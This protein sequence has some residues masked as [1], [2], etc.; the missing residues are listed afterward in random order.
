MV[1]AS[2]KI[3]SKNIEG[4]LEL[5][6]STQS[7]VVRGPVRNWVSFSTGARYSN[8]ERYTRGLQVTGEFVPTFWD[9]QTQARFK[10]SAYDRIDVFAATF[11]SD[12]KMKPKK[13]RLRYNCSVLRHLRVCDEFAGSGSGTERF[14]YEGD[15]VA[16]SWTHLA[17][18][19][20]I[21]AHVNFSRSNERE[22]TDVEYSIK[23]DSIRS[24]ER[25]DSGLRLAKIEGGLAGTRDFEIVDLKVGAGAKHS[26]LSGKM[27]SMQKVSYD[28]GT[29][30]DES[31][32]F[33]IDRGDVD[34]FLYFQSKWETGSASMLSGI[35][36]VRF[37]TT[38][39]RLFLPRLNIRLKANAGLAFTLSAGRHAQPPFY[40]EYVVDSVARPRLK[41][42]KSDQFGVGV[43]YEL[44]NSLNW[45][46]EVF[47]RDQSELISYQIDDL[48]IVYSGKN[49]SDGFAYGINTKT[50]GQLDSLIGI[51]SY[52]YL[53]AREDIKGD[54]RRNIPRPVD[55]RH[56]VSVY[57]EDRMYL[58]FLRL[59]NLLYS[60]FHIRMLYGSG[61]P[62]TPQ[63][64]AK[65]QIGDPVLV[66]GKR[67]SRRD[68][69]YLR[70]DIGMTQ[71]I[72]IAGKTMHLHQE[73]ANMFDQHN[74]VGYSYFPSFRGE[75]VEVR[76]S[77][78][79]RVYNFSVSVKF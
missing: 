62:H 45:T 77:L 67:N 66:E 58:E 54:S 33:T 6:G 14:K 37:G 63:V 53:V 8:L 74:V 42:Q 35:R 27:V 16:M 60:R 31:T 4:D 7:I 43:N 71:A 51:A 12:F 73:V 38:D 59:R 26:G 25:H 56:T 22:D 72:D 36:V 52:S 28:R 76:R 24:L 78:G 11:T 3:D 19:G 55:Q 32:N 47:Y 29:F 2:Y 17:P 40:K 9:W 44:K 50:R 10:I 30:L 23:P 34:T 79:R 70:F 41:S 20:A 64:L 68:R 13:I 48:R 15:V 61:F 49:D 57:L 39:E 5:S 1:E 21:K 65:S 18:I 75:P 69:P 46:T